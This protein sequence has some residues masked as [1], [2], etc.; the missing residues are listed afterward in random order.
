MTKSTIFN[1]NDIL[2]AQLE[3]LSDDDLKGEELEEE[4]ARS[5]AISMISKD[6]ISNARLALDVCKYRDVSGDEEVPR[7]LI[8]NDQTR[9]PMLRKSLGI[10]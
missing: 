10:N 5:K 4:V 2:F 3:K 9:E 7:L 8:G 6:V 1:L